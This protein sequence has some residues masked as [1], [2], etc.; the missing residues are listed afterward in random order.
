MRDALTEDQAIATI[1][2]RLGDA[3][4]DDLFCPMPLR[5]GRGTAST[6]QP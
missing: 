2:E 5:I 1:Y 4:A 6:S 3:A